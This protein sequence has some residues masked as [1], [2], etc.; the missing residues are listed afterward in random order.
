MSK[1]TLHGFPASTYL[2]T[3][4]MAAIEKGIGHEIDP[5]TPQSPEQ[6]AMHPW[7]K[8]PAM[9][10][11]D[12]KL[13][14]TLAISRYIDEAFEGPALQPADVAERAKMNQWIS[15][16][17]DYTYRPTVD[18]VLQRLI[19]PSRG[20]TP[21]EAFIAECVPKAEKALGVLDQALA[22]SSY[23][24][25]DT[26]T[27]ADLYVIPLINYLPMTPEGKDLLAKTGNLARWQQSMEARDSAQQSF[28]S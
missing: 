8:L 3:C 10:H 12:L 25:G 24:V 28:Q 23:F 27:L 4:R 13:Y 16:F 19:V 9:T 18:I 6:L 20:G 11:G 21:D 17:S 15:V 26:L 7:G 14:E 1:I 22:D 2:R 5:T